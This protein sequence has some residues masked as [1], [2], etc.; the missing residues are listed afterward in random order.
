MI[1]VD[2]HHYIHF[3]EIVNLCTFPKSVRQLLL[4]MKKPA[5]EKEEVEVMNTKMP[6]VPVL[7]YLET[8]TTIMLILGRKMIQLM[9]EDAAVLSVCS[10]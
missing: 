8:M 2:H 1:D 10:L 9:Y 6:A 5:I 4:C 7:S 3:N